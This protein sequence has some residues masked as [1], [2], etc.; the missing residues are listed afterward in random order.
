MERTLDSI[1]TADVRRA[2]DG[3][4]S[5]LEGVLRRLERPF[6]NLA[7]RMMLS[8]QDAEDATQECL[9]RIATR[10]SQ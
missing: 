1:T 4:R 5:A 3:D 2:V 6:F 9:V 8:P 10:L 7:T